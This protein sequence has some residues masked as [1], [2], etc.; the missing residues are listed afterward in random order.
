ML[1]NALRRL[2][3][4]TAKHRL[5][6]FFLWKNLAMTLEFLIFKSFHKLMQQTV[7]IAC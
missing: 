3:C 4:L 1:R 5:P 7:I 6:R 2:F